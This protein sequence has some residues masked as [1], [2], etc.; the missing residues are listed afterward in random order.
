MAPLAT[1]AFPRYTFPMQP[2]QAK[3]LRDFYIPRFRSEQA[4]TRRILAAVPADQ[5]EYKPDPKCMNALKLCWHIAGTEMWFLDAV[6]EHVF[7]DD[8]PATLFA[9]KT[10]A[11]VA[12]WYEDNFAQR[13]PRLAAL[14]GEHLAAPVNWIGLRNDPAVTY[15]SFGLRHS[16]HHRGFLAAYLRPMGARI[17]AIYVQSADERLPPDSLSVAAI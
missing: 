10:G 15:L 16:V 13:L 1:S 8:D 6:L 4:I 14:S 11:E 9:T 17:P 3:F 7:K 5:S 2:E 12:A